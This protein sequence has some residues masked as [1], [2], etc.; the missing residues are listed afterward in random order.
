[1]HFLIK[2]F[3]KASLSLLF[4]LLT[5]YLILVIFVSPVGEFHKKVCFPWWVGTAS[6]KRQTRN[7]NDDMFSA[8][9][10]VEL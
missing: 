5:L 2:Y 8:D 10:G 3:I 7:Y 1:M 4:T 6:I 9:D